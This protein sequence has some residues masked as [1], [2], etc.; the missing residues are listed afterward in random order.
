VQVEGA[1]AEHETSQTRSAEERVAEDRADRTFRHEACDIAGATHGFFPT[2]DEVVEPAS[3]ARPVKVLH[4][5]GKPI[6]RIISL[7]SKAPRGRRGDI[8]MDEAAH[9]VNCRS[10]YVGSTVLIM[11]SQGQ[12]TMASTPLGKR[13]IF[14]EIGTEALRKYPHYSRSCPYSCVERARFLA[15]RGARFLA[16][17]KKEEGIS[18]LR[19]R[20]RPS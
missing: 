10:V 9:H 13:G 18:R 15:P 20:K 17:P 6:R 3:K 12:L 14:C 4:C 2:R 11:R 1:R 5:P 7:P 16:P 19:H 8:Y